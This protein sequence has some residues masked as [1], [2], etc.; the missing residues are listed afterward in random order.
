MLIDDI[1]MLV[2]D[3][4]PL[5]VGDDK[6]Y[7]LVRDS[8]HILVGGGIFVIFTAWRWRIYNKQ[9]NECMQK[10]TLSCVVFQETTYEFN[11][12]YF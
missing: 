12:N 5:L 3:D 11:N 2:G 4:I 1:L 7:M 6:L 10:F 9:G 8:M